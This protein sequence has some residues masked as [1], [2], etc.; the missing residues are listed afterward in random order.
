M[1]KVRFETPGSIGIRSLANPALNLFSEELIEDLRTV[2]NQ[3]KQFPLRAL[4]VRADGKVFR[5]RRRKHF[6]GKGRD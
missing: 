6:Q 5:W 3:A 4:L 2:V 1:N